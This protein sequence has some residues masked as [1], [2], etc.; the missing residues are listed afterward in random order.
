MA[1]AKRHNREGLALIEAAAI[2]RHLHNEL[3]KKMVR[4]LN[5]LLHRALDEYAHRTGIEP[6]KIDADIEKQVAKLRDRSMGGA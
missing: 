6:A 2:T 1:R 4:R 3:S 5:A